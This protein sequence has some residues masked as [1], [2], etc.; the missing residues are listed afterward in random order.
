MNAYFLTCNRNSSFILSL[1]G[2]LYRA[3]DLFLIH[4]DKKS[5]ADVQAVAANLSATYSNIRVID[6]RPYS[7]AG[8]S[9]VRTTLD[10]ISIALVADRNWTH[11]VT[12]SEQHLPTMPPDA[13]DELLRHRGS[14]VGGRRVNDM[15]RHERLDIETRL[16]LQYE[17]LPGVGAFSKGMIALDGNLM[18]RLYHGSN[19]YILSRKHCE[20]LRNQTVIEECERFSRSV[21]ADEIAIQTLLWSPSALEVDFI[22]NKETTFVAWPH[23]TDNNDMVFVERNFWEAVNKGIPFIRKRPVILPEA[24]D[25]YLKRAH[26]VDLAVAPQ[27]ELQAIDNTVTRS[28]RKQDIESSIVRYVASF[29]E[30]ARVDLHE[31]I[32]ERPYLF[33]T[34][35][36]QGFGENSIVVL[37]E[38][39]VQAKI[40]LTKRHDFNGF[41][42]PYMEGCREISL[43]RV[44][45]HGLFFQKD[46]SVPGVENYGFI[47]IGSDEGLANLLSSLDRYLKAAIE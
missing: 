34:I 32:S 27:E 28:K 1:L 47:E 42:L 19:W 7:W 12:L 15:P 8:F 44:R 26:Y 40:V 10:A 38:D 3:D 24:V 13:L 22:E 30:Q 36:C 16:A 25:S 45:V 11:F 31:H 29:S 21:H 14:L 35:Q 6:S 46:I 2:C 23:L 5:S 17:E 20:Y 43:I 37:S 4:C 9:Q 41:F 18:D 33:V 39:L